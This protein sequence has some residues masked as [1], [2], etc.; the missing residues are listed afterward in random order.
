M[1]FWP[2]VFLL[3]FPGS[4]DGKES[5]CHA[6]DLGW[7]DLLE[8][9]TTTHS[10]ILAWRSPWTGEPGGLQSPWGR[11]ESDTTGQ[12]STAHFSG[13]TCLSVVIQTLF[14]LKYL[15]IYLLTV[16]GLRCPPAYGILL[17]QP[18]IEPA[19]PVLQGGFST[20]GPP[21]KSL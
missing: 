7:E 1:C 13:R 6:G 11:K 9:G 10:S 5:T 12:L 18:G 3:G 17:P 8:K 19:S 14:F 16:S 2:W 4:S 20:T 15:F 21:G